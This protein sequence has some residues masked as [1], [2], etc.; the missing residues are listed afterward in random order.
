MIAVLLFKG[1][2]YVS[3]VKQLKKSVKV[4]S[5]YNVINDSK[6]SIR[7]PLEQNTNNL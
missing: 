4:E 2:T 3:Y 6:N 5:V 7:I 1:Y